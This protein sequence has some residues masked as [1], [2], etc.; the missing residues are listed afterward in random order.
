MLLDQA[1]SFLSGG[2]LF[3][4]IFLV[5]FLFSQQGRAARSQKILGLLILGCALNA[6]HPVLV[7]MLDRLRLSRHPDSGRCRRPDHHPGGAGV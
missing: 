6:A 3:V 4:G 5:L 2:T 7:R 1:F